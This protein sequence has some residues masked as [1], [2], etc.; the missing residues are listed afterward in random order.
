LQVRSGSADL[1][2]SDISMPV[3]DGIELF[4]SVRKTSAP[5]PFIFSGAR[6]ET[7]AGS[8]SAST[9]SPR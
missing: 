8:R 4:E 1:I 6:R 2:L 7:F 9:T 5:D 3:M